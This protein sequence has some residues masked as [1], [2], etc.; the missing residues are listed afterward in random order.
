MSTCSSKAPEAVKIGEAC[1]LES[2]RGELYYVTVDWLPCATEKN[3]GC[4]VE[5]R[6]CVRTKT[7]RTSFVLVTLAFLDLVASFLLV[8]ISFCQQ[9]VSLVSSLYSHGSD[10]VQRVCGSV[11][12]PLR[13]DPFLRLLPRPFHV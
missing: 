5:F 10:K 6:S 9:K 12:L 13:S 3:G 11:C 2:V 4:R 7:R 8:S 1:S